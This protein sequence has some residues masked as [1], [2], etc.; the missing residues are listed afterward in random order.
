M[1]KSFLLQV[2]YSVCNIMRG[3][4][5]RAAGISSPSCVVLGLFLVGALFVR[6]V[7]VVV[8][9]R[10]LLL[11]LLLP[12]HHLLHTV[13]AQQVDWAIALHNPDSGRRTREENVNIL[14]KV[15]S[16]LHCD[17]GHLHL[18]LVEADA[19]H[20]NN[21][22]LPLLRL[23]HQYRS[24]DQQPMIG[25]RSVTSSVIWVFWV[26]DNILVCR[27]EG[28]CPQVFLLHI[29]GKDTNHLS[30]AFFWATDS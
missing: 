17:Q 19:F 26:P 2:Y 11:C 15:K 25:T 21:G 7:V 24:L 29:V 23:W 5:K 16:T 28:G 22:H 20:L 3:F 18:G 12:L 9:L 6:G 8:I 4:S 27:I 1:V 30:Q 14:L 10:I 13:A